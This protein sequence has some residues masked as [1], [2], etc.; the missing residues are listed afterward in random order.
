M[1]E[2]KFQN[3]YLLTSVYIVDILQAQ[4]DSYYEYSFIKIKVK[5]YFAPEIFQF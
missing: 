3:I 5:I 2:L 1:V 4:K